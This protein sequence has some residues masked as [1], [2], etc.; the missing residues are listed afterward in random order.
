MNR[1][2]SYWLL[3]FDLACWLYVLATLWLT[4]CGSP[5]NPVPT[6][7][8]HLPAGKYKSMLTDFQTRDNRKIEKKEL[9]LG[10][11]LRRLLR[12]STDLHGLLSRLW[13]C[14]LVCRPTGRYTW[15]R[16]L[17]IDERIRMEKKNRWLS[18]V[19]QFSSFLSFLGICRKVV[20]IE[21]KF[22]YFRFELYRSVWKT[23]SKRTGAPFMKLNGNPG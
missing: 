22:W 15:W 6:G 19:F 17:E 2:L 16:L 12:I 13:K 18:L 10:H 23:V 4:T 5:Q 1:A 20:E 14:L 7:G 9:F 3:I 11:R 8:L 21:M